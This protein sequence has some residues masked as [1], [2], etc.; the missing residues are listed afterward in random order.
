M[1]DNGLEVLPGHQPE[2]QLLQDRVAELS[3][4]DAMIEA[5]FSDM[6]Q[7]LDPS[8]P[9]KTHIQN[10]LNGHFAHGPRGNTGDN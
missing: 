7:Q 6:A 5:A 10:H 2:R 1:N 3:A 9:V 8:D 4:A